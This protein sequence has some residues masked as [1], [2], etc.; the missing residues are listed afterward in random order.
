LA[1]LEP[2]IANRYYIADGEGGSYFGVNRSLRAKAAGKTFSFP[3]FAR[4][5]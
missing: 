1:T 4:E 3:A 5:L 2:L